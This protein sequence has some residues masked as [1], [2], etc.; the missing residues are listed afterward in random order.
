MASSS[1]N[2]KI[3]NKQKSC[4]IDLGRK[5]IVYLLDRDPL[6]LPMLGVLNAKRSLLRPGLFVGEASIKGMDNSSYKGPQTVTSPFLSF[7]G[8]LSLGLYFPHLQNKVF[9]PRLK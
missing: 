3:E 4:Q 7:S 1:K 8:S 6:D 9:L 5:F 2:R